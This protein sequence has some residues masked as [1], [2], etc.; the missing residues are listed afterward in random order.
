LNIDSVIGKYLYEVRAT[1]EILPEE[2]IAKVVDLLA[3]TRRE[4]RRV[5]LFGNGGSA[6]TASHF[7]SDLSKGAMVPGKPP[8]KAAALTD[9]I[10]LLTAWANDTAYGNIFSKQVENVVEPGDVV[11]CISGSGNSSN[12]LKGIRAAKTKGAITV[13]FIGFDGGKLKELV[14][15]AV[16]VPSNVM[17]QVEDIHLL[18]EHIITT[19]LRGMP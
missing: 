10:S 9:N 3:Q 8:I 18:I 6:A 19:C 4:S 11:I 16:I 7:A 15:I 1:L 13:G 5:F 2:K 14:D 12:V 17:E